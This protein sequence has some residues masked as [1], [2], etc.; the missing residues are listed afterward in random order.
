MKNL[1]VAES[2]F[3]K[4]ELY[5][6]SYAV[7]SEIADTIHNCQWFSFAYDPQA[8][9]TLGFYSKATGRAMLSVIQ[10]VTKP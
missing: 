9:R 1:D 6:T 10:L 4:S 8:K 5:E 3:H 2:H 7:G